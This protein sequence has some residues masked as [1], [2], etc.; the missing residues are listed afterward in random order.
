SPYAR[1]LG[2]PVAG[3]GTLWYAAVFLIAL[4]GLRAPPEAERWPD[5]R[6]LL[7]SSSGLAF[8]A[9]LTFVE[10]FLLHAICRW[11]VASALLTLFIFGLSLPWSQSSVRP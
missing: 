7:L 1:F 6:L 3:W 11:C 4:L 5:R 9:Y 10:L 8:S 2:V